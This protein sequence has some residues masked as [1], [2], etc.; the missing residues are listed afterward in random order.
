MRSVGP[1]A[2]YTRL[3]LALSRARSD[4]N[5]Q[6]RE[7]EPAIP[8][9][10]RILAKHSVVSLSKSSGTGSRLGL[11]PRSSENSE[12]K[13]ALLDLRQR[14]F[15]PLH[16]TVIVRKSSQQLRTSS[17]CNLFRERIHLVL[18]DA[19]C[20]SAISEQTPSESY[21]HDANRTKK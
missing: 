3:A 2:A 18:Y 6:T 17:F 19:T 21:N 12:S 11:S 1:Q 20:S 8:R 4:R 13:R 14:E 5:S 9:V 10:E 15:N 16:S 7:T